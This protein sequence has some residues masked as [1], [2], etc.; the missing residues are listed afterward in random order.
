M[1][2]LIVAFLSFGLL[3][4]LAKLWTELKQLK[5]T[6]EPLKKTE[7]D[8]A[9]D[10]D[11]L[12]N[13]ILSTKH[14]LDRLESR[15]QIMS[16]PNVKRNPLGLPVALFPEEPRTFINPRNNPPSGFV[17]TPIPRTH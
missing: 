15:Y 3:V 16:D 17:R 6:D 13:E 10:E 4:P 7:S 8:C 5:K 11:E 14:A 9:T 1:W 12:V 2:L